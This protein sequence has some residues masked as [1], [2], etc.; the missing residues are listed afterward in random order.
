[1][2][3]TRPK[4]P[5]NLSSHSELSK[6][7]S[8]EMAWHLHYVEK[9]RGEQSEAMAR[10]TIMHTLCNAFWRPSDG[11]AGDWRTEVAKMIVEDGADHQHVSVDTVV[12]EPYA[13]CIWLMKRYERHYAPMLSQVRVLSEEYDARAKIPGTR[14]KHQAI[15]DNIWEIGDFLWMVERKTYG[16]ADKSS[17]VD[18]DPQLTNNLWV[19]R[20]SLGLDIHGIIWDGIYTHRWMPEKPTQKA[21]IEA[22]LAGNPD[23][24]AQCVTG[25]ER[26]EWARA[27]V[28]VH[29]GVERPDS[30]SF[31]MLY[32]DRTEKHIAAAQK[33]IR[34]VLRR[35]DALR[36]GAIP[37]RNL[38]PFCRS[39]EGQSECFDRLA[40]PLDTDVSA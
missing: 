29:P 23:F 40:F 6:L 38:G 16:R 15:I 37:I 4:R 35:R 12:E 1:M 19:A 32:L 22:E 14:N 10:G 2:T 21:L 5:L 30:E 3:T 28:E 31:E 20:T 26:T 39:C 33:E 7:A 24:A 9:I 8:C 17:M 25:K 36:R 27:Q 13:T 34:A 11:S 18:V